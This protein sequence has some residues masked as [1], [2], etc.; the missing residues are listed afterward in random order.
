MIFSTSVMPV[1]MNVLQGLFCACTIAHFFMPLSCITLFSN[2]QTVTRRR[3]FGR[4]FH[5]L[6]C[7]AALMF[8][9]VSLRSMNAEQHERMFQQ[10]KGISKGTTN[11]NPNLIITNIIQRLHFEKKCDAVSTQESEIKVFARALGR[12][13]NTLIPNHILE[14]KSSHYQAH[15]ERISDYLATGPGVWWRKTAKGIEFFDGEN[16]LQARQP[17]PQLSHYHSKT[18]SDI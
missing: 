15:L 10:A 2:P 17:G 7:H 18:I 14:K 11:H 8:R 9:I 3:L 5:S 6:I 16:K 1:T 4:Y 13:R 12:M